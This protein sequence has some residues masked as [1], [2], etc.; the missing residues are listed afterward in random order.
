MVS[1]SIQAKTGRGSPWVSLFQ[2]LLFWSASVVLIARVFRLGNELDTIDWL[3]S[4]LFHLSL[5]PSVAVNGHLLIPRLL[6]QRRFALYFFGFFSAIGASILIHHWV[7]SYLADWIFP[8]YYF[9]SYLKWWEIGLYVLAYLVVTGLF[10][11]SVDYFHSERL[12]GQQE[13]MEKERLDDEL[14]ALKAQINPHFLF[15]NLNLLYS[16][17]IKKTDDLPD[18]IVQ[19]SD[20]L[21]YV[22]YQTNQPL[23]RMDA[24]LK[25]I[26][27]YIALSQKRMHTESQIKWRHQLDRTDIQIPPLLFLPLVEN[28]IKHGVLDQ[29]G[30]VE[31]R[32]ELVQKGNT[33]IFSSVNARAKAKTDASSGGMG[34]SNLRKRLDR[35]F[36]EGHQLDAEERDEQFVVRMELNLDKCAV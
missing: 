15:N 33:L 2:F 14:N 3:F 5:T 16:L 6:Q 30:A 26:D 21:R 25:M 31:L 35:L 7:M 22:M 4:L 9:I 8:G 17:S 23:V 12:R 36:P 20:L 1:K 19:L 28:G 32:M 27:D 18:H 24:E 34:L 29:R 10:Q 13:Q 11:L